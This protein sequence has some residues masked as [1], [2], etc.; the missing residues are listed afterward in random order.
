MTKELRGS[1]RMVSQ[2]IK[3]INRKL[4]IILKNRK[5]GVQKYN[6]PTE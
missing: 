5:Y 4:E 3:N 1:M 2:Q 6:I